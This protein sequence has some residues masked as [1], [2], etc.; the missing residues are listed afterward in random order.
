LLGEI[1]MQ[2]GQAAEAKRRLQQSLALCVAGGD[3][4]GEAQAIRGLGRLDL[5]AGRL[6]AAQFRLHAALVTFD[7]FQMR[8]PWVGCL[9]D[10]AAL[11]VALGDP[12]SGC[13]LAAAAQRMR[14]SGH[15]ARSPNQLEH[16][17]EVLAQL[18][19]ALGKEVFDTLWAAASGWDAGE[20][21]RC[22]LGLNAAAPASR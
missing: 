7:G 9:E 11:A 14:D 19:S 17:Q 20:V 8:G 5:Q 13:A 15:L 10:H 6:E 21:K 2:A 1:E 3:R 12:T 22:A 16:W 4:R 18:R